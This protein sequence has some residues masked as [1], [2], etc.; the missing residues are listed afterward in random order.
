MKNIN[1][2]IDHTNLKQ[3]IIGKDIDKL[4]AEAKEYNFH[5]ICINPAWI[6]YA[7]KAIDEQQLKTKI[8]TVIGFFLGQSTTETKTFEAM[9]AVRKGADELDFVVNVSLIK[10]RRLKELNAQLKLMREATNGKEIKLIIESS[11]LSD[12]EKILITK[13]LIE[14]KFDFVKTA[15]GL[16]KGGA[17]V[18]DIKLLKSVA[19][20]KIRIKASGGIKTSEQAKSLIEAGAD[21][22]GTS[23]GIPIAQGTKGKNDY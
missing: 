21:R 16:A 11:L 18:E 4:I 10:E 22:I 19:K 8:C 13:M 15:T 1:K 20:D 3:D 7:R 17:T 2:Y 5:S 12:E 9:D 6:A 14:H 23:N